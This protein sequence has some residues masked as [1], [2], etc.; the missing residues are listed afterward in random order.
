MSQIDKIR[1]SGT[2]YDIVD[3]TAVHSLEG[4]ATEAYVTGATAALAQAIDNQHYQTSGDVQS[5]ISS[6]I[7]SFFGAVDY[8]S[9]TKRINFYNET[10]GGTVLAYVDATDFIKDGMVD[11]VEIKTLSGASY[12]AITF[13]SDAGKEEIDI[14][15]T[16]IFDPSNYYTKQEVNA[17]LSGKQDTLSAGTGI[18]ISGN[19]ISSTAQ[20]TVDQTII[21]N[22]TNAVAGGAVY[23]GL[24][25]KNP[26][27]GI[28][29]TT[30][31][32]S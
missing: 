2:T 30:L 22:S 12:L 25:A 7:T 10:T 17:S 28:S 1:L 11:N 9:N 27:V 21:Q 15:L 16:D 24:A 5:A 8:D 18:S 29:G 23:D 19:V 6:S 13:N 32:I 14:P 26:M 20:V 4:Y 3:S 31:I